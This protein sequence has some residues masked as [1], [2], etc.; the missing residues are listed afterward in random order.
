MAHLS[1]ENRRSRG[2]LILVTAFALAVSFVALALVLNSVIYTENLA[3][4][5]ESAKASDAVKV[6]SDMVD[7]TAQ[8][9]TYVN[10]YNA[11]EADTYS[12]L[13]DEIRVGVS[14]TT[15]FAREYQNVNGQAINTTLVATEKGTWIN[16]TF[17]VENKNFTDAN[18]DPSWTLVNDTEGTRR[19][20][21]NVT[22]PD[23]LADTGDLAAGETRSDLDNFTVVA[24]D[25]SVS[26]A[27]TWKMELFHDDADLIGSGSEYVLSVVVDGDQRPTCTVPNGVEHFWVNVSAG[28]VSGEDCRALRFAENTG[29]V[30]DISY[31]NGD[32]INGT[33]RL[34]VNNQSALD[35]T[36][37]NSTVTAGP[38]VLD[39]AIWGGKILVDYEEQRMVYETD[40]RVVPGESDD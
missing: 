11:S 25:R 16:Q 4:R 33:Y 6:K 30:Y 36:H 21:M 40:A 5:S 17:S 29:G 13:V 19:F 20:R 35:P 26:P 10:E 9:M 8:I 32:K 37:Y 22:D 31:W 1:N 27:K 12:D 15:Q 18:G 7:G 28:T 39:K 14:N 2:Q 38:P 3:T 23:A 24:R 34:M